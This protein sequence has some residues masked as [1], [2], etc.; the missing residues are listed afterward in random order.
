MNQSLG[1]L[2]ESDRNDEIE[3][4]SLKAFIAAI[5][6]DRFRVRAEQGKDKGVDRYLEVKVTGHDT[7]LR[8]QIQFKGMEKASPNADSSISKSIDVSNLNY[9][10]NG[11]C[12]LY[13]LF[14]VSTGELRYAWARDEA[15]RLQ[16]E[17]SL[18]MNAGTVTIRFLKILNKAALDD[19]QHRIMTES[20]INRT[21]NERLVQPSRSES[22]TF[23]VDYD[24][25]ITDSIQA[26]EIIQKSGITYVACG[27]PEKV[28]ELAG[29]LAP[30]VL[31]QSRSQLVLAYAQYVMSRYDTAMGHVRECSLNGSKLT[32]ADKWLLEELRNSC[33]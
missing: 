27:F 16:Q 31:H 20:R 7:N 24:G 21:I 28:V 33:E 2:P 9:L 8:S 17:N 14:E 22:P 30:K 1:P 4:L 18:W 25:T 13:I 6:V 19:I 10:L 26:V 23:Q 11:P 29:L 3:D 12:P 5:P 32:N 15:A